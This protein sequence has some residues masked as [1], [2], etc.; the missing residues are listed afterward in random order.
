MTRY[1]LL[2]ICLMVAA[3][4]TR[5]IPDVHHARVWHAEN[6]HA[7]ATTGMVPVYAPHQNQAAVPHPTAVRP[8]HTVPPSQYLAPPATHSSPP[9]TSPAYPVIVDDTLRY[10]T[11]PNQPHSFVSPPSSVAAI[12]GGNTSGDFTQLILQAENQSSGWVR[13]VLAQSRA[14]TDRQEIVKG[15]CWDYLDAAWS[16]AGVSRAMRQTIYKSS[17]SGAYANLNDLRAGDW[18]YHVN[19]SYHNIEHSGMF[20]AWVDR[21]RNLGLT[22]SYAG[23]N[24]QEPARYKVYDLSS[25]YNI[26]RA[27]S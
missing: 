13:H 7:R 16:R 8:A 20:I 22:L 9:S 21:S 26:M 10:P 1:T 4:A 6:G 11:N 25:V 17:I 18:I 27:P 19:H 23:E 2:P 14:M 15:G 12:V 5:P 24:R 3:C